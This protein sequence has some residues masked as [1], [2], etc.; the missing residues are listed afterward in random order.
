[1]NLAFRC[2]LGLLLASMLSACGQD[3]PAPEWS[4]AELA[5]IDSLRISKLGRPPADP[6]NR[7]ADD[8]RAAALGKKLFSDPRLSANGK[9]ACAT[10]HQPDKFFTD[11]LATSRGLGPTPR[12]AP[13]LLTAA[14]SP[15]LFWDGRADSLWAQ[16]TG[17]LQNS[18]EMG[19]TPAA[20]ARTLAI[21]YR[22]DYQTIFGPLAADPRRV[23]TNAGKALAAYVR[24]LRP[25][26][27]RFDAYAESLQ[28]K[29]RNADHVFG[30]Q[31]RLG[32]KLF[33]GRGQCLRCHHGPL[34]TNQGFHNTGL[35]ALPGQMPDLG[36]VQGVKEALASEFNCR[37]P[38]SD[39]P[40]PQCPQL[41]YARV[42]TPELVGA[43]KA[44]SLRNVAETGPYMHDGR[45]ATLREVID[46]YNRA[47]GISTRS[48]HTEIF[49]LGFFAGELDALEMFLSTLSST[50][51]APGLKPD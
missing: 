6:S 49:P 39:A 14:W 7:Y 19:L 44:P 9:I 18:H 12:N 30:A 17:P 11:G 35:E 13:S 47:P 41:D 20:L 51:L 32:L 29:S 34:F 33:L 1:M 23:M 48:G 15:W 4:T 27:G 46:H 16:A 2:G 43:F 31:E 10:C 21:H 40:K 37:G 36:R 8:P 3:S 22:D 50:P 26:P 5:Q 25:A 24:T 38:Y 28:R 45:F 42:G